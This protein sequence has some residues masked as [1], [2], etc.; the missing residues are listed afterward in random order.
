MLCSVR[1]GPVRFV[2]V[3][4][5]LY[6][7]CDKSMPERFLP[8]LGEKLE[9]RWY[10]WNYNRELFR[11]EEEEKTGNRIKRFFAFKIFAIGMGIEFI[12]LLCS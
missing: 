4:F 8:M 3:T 10:V 1:F 9:K 7:F 6:S 2:K 12:H 5:R 11:D